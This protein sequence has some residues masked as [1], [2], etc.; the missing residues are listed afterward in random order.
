MPAAAAVSGLLGLDFLRDHVL[1]VDFP[2][3]LITLA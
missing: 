3:G 2:A 1:T